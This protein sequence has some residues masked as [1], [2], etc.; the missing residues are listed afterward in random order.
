MKTIKIVFIL[1]FTVFYAQAQ[2]ER[3]IVLTTNNGERFIAYIN[4][5]QINN[6]PL[7]QV[8]ING[9]F[10]NF[11]NVE[12]VTVSNKHF[13]NNLYLP[14]LSEIVYAYSTKTSYQKEH[15]YIQDIYPLQNTVQQNGTFIYGQQNNNGINNGLGQINININNQMNTQQ[16][17][18]VT[19]TPVEETVV[20]VEGYTG[21]IGCE[22]PINQSRF[23]HMLSTIENQDFASSKKRV[24]K[25]IISANCIVTSQLQRILELFDFESDKLEMA[26]YAYDYTYDI[27]NYYTINNVFDFESSIEK[28][29]KFIRNK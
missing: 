22:I 21:A 11:Y 25:Q 17:T 13:K 14:P 10:D 5:E 12:L 9:L 28:L 26:K 6:Q 19:T 2:Q 4:Q 23:D 15:Y 29:D 1:V 8:K 24:A 16:N 7:S 27:E 3:S 18:T 20:Y